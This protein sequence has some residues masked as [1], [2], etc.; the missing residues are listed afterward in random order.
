MINRSSPILEIKNVS[1]TFKTNSLFKKN[2]G[3]KVLSNI[4]LELTKG[5]IFA[6]IGQSGSGKTTFAKILAGIINYDSGQIY[7]NKK[8]L[9]QC[10]INNI[11]MIFQNPLSSFDPRFSIIDSILEPL[12]YFKNFENEDE[13]IK[14]ISMVDLETKLLSRYPH[15]LSGGQLQRAAIVRALSTEPEVLVCDEIT[16]ALDA[17]SKLKILDLLVKINQNSLK[18]IIFITHDLDSVK[19]IC[20]KTMVLRNGKVVEQGSTEKIINNPESNYTKE[21]FL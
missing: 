15:Q 14:L 21:L 16:S 10:S 12:K 17:S 1:K 19:Y 3:Y 18:T 13:V 5:D 4:S 11:Q 2:E 9:N 6:I 7:L 20:N 8:K